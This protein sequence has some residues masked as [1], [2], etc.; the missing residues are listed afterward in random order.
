MEVLEMVLTL[1]TYLKELQ[2]GQKEKQ[3]IFECL[4]MLIR[5]CERNFSLISENQREF[6]E[7]F[8]TAGNKNPY[9]KLSKKSLKL[10]NIQRQVLLQYLHKLNKMNHFFIRKIK[11]DDLDYIDISLVSFLIQEFFTKVHIFQSML[12]EKISKVLAESKINYQS[13][14]FQKQNTLFE[15][16]RLSMRIFE[17]FQQDPEGREELEKLREEFSH[18]EIYDILVFAKPDVTNMFIYTLLSSY[19]E[20]NGKDPTFHWHQLV[21]Y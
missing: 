15:P 21:G 4:Q 7:F 10:I 13:H 20:E 17:V 18:E 11:Q 14:Y 2:P 16:Q 1:L 12:L 9:Q 8:E 3:Y 5:S 6:V 19:Y